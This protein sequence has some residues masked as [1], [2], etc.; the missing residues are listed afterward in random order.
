MV[1]YRETLLTEKNKKSREIS[2]YVEQ[3]V[4]SVPREGLGINITLDAQAKGCYPSDEK[5][6]QDLLKQLDELAPSWLCI[7]LP[8]QDVLTAEGKLRKDAPELAQFDRL[9][10]YCT[11]KELDVV[12]MF[13]KSV[14]EWMRFRNAGG[15]QPAPCNAED[16]ARVIA[17][18]M[19]Y[20]VK[21]CGYSCLKYSTI[22]GEPFNE[23]GDEFSFATPEDIDPYIYY[24]QVHEA[25][26]KALD[27]KGLSSVGL[28][29]PNSA[30]VYAHLETFR[31]AKE[32]GLDITRDMSAIDLHAYRMRL[33]Y[34]PPSRHI[35]TCG[36]SEYLEQYLGKAIELAKEN[37]KPLY[38]TELGCMY[39]GK[40]RYGDNR[41]PSRHECFI[42]EAELIVRALNMGIDGI[43]KWVL[44][45]DTTELRGHYHLL[46][47]IDGS[48]RKK[49][50]YYGFALLY[51]AIPKGS[52]MLRI[53]HGGNA[54]GIYASASE[55][56]DG[57]FNIILV[58]DHPTDIA[59][60][61]IKITQDMAGRNFGQWNVDYWDKGVLK[62]TINPGNG[63]LQVSL[64]PL[65]MNVITSA[66]FDLQ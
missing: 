24:A 61:E 33:D 11:H 64:P 20:F 59:D 50:G 7:T 28:L 54:S 65:S 17:D 30:D 40:S 12:L 56:S 52:R 19:C 25:T 18:A 3:D 39:Y 26:R 10:K 37:G 48:Y 38:I 44:L 9:C 13:P 16:Y 35:F 53:S 41:G 2:F 45:F 63:I 51:K 1:D 47:R 4:I 46:E 31:R 62:N 27:A 14:P 22:F 66:T 43:L 6:W 29:G 5:G 57:N 55:S 32:R 42:A 58:N 49:D 8:A 15:A 60:V 36:L 34:M 21:E 23:D